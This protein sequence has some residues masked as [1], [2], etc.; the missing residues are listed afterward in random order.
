LDVLI[1]KRHGIN[2]NF[3]PEDLVEVGNMGVRSVG[4]QKMRAEA[5]SALKAMFSEMDLAN[6]PQLAVLSGFRSYERQ[7]TVKKSWLS[8]LGISAEKVSADAGHSEHQLGTTVDFSYLDGSF[9]NTADASWQWLNENAHEYGFVMTYRQNNQ[10]FTGY[11]FEPWHWR[12]VG[13]DLATEI[14]T[15]GRRPERM[16]Q[17]LGCR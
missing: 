17:A 13:K 16:Y 9:I 3:E 14:Y 11:D 2:P 8:V 6:L 15:T 10:K 1:S 7:K 5:L 4:A 12:Y